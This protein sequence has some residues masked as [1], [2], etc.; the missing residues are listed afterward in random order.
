MP[1][2]FPVFSKP[3]VNLRGMGVGSQRILTPAA[4]LRSLKP[5]HFWME[6]LTGV[7]VSS[8]FAVQDGRAMWS[9]HTTGIPAKRGTFDYWIIVNCHDLEAGRRAREALRE[10]FMRQGDGTAEAVEPHRQ[11]IAHV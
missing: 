8:D 1:D 7:H 10:S 5:G 11:E 3:I 2:R 6:L 9:R 4:Y